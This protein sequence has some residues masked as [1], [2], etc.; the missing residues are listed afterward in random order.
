[1]NERQQRQGY[2]KD[3]SQGATTSSRWQ[4]YDYLVDS[5][6]GLVGSRVGGSTNALAYNLWTIVD[7]QAK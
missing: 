6:V 7:R 1:M 2:A 4:H 5:V 3:G